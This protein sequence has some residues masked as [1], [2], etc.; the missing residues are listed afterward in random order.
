MT[1]RLYLDEDTIPGLARLL[2]ER[3]YDVTSAHEIGALRISD[4]QQ[5]DHATSEQRAIVTSN[6]HD[7]RRIAVECADAG[8]EHWGIILVYRQYH[9]DQLGVALRAFV[10]FL[11]SADADALR[12]T[13]HVLDDRNIE[14]AG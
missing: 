11:D 4:E 14:V 9:R 10:R 5:L 3:G 8:R 1:P 6:H 7:F 13:T 12:N 2:R